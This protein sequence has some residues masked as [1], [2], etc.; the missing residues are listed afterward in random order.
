MKNESIVYTECPRCA[1]LWD[2]TECDNCH[3]PNVN[4]F[5]DDNDEFFPEDYRN[6]AVTF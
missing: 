4:T 6:D 2:G 1:E 5:I 3:Y